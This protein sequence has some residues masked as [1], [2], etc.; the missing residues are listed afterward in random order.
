M[1]SLRILFYMT[2]VADGLRCEIEAP[3]F[4]AATLVPTSL[5]QYH[6]IFRQPSQLDQCTALHNNIIGHSRGCALWAVLRGAVVF[7][8]HMNRVELG[9][10]VLRYRFVVLLVAIS[11]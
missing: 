8:Y 9:S 5:P 1:N 7:E 10:Q 2:S 6:A 4:S 3:S 11:G